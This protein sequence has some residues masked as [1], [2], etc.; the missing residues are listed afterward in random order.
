MRWRQDDHKFKGSL[1][2][3]SETI[4]QKQNENDK[5]KGWD[6]VHWGRGEFFLAEQTDPSSSSNFA[7]INHAFGVRW[8]LSQHLGPKDFLFVFLKDVLFFVLHF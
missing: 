7:L 4:S 3:V 6:M 5:Q 2:K 8:E 1:G